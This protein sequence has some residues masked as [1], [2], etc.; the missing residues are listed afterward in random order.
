M[1]NDYE[2]SDEKLHKHF[3]FNDK[4]MMLFES[5]SLNNQSSFKRLAQATHNAGL[6]CWFV[7]GDRI[8]EPDLRACFGRKGSNPARLYSVILASANGITGMTIHNMRNKQFPVI[9]RETPLTE[10]RVDQIKK[11][12]LPNIRK[13]WPRWFK[14]ERQGMWPDEIV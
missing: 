7:K 11:E 2:L 10:I 8:P 9:E 13:L 4:F 1:T 5:C 6:D 3:G 14:V 12:L